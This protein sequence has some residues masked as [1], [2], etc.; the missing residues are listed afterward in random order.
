QRY[1]KRSA[2]VEAMQWTGGNIDAIWAWA[3][4]EG[5]DGPTEENSDQLILTT[6]YGDRAIARVEDWV[7]PEPQP[8]RF[9]PCQGDILEAIYEPVED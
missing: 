5:I 1:P 3:G 2:V 6:I 4:A 9:Y 7:I 8:G